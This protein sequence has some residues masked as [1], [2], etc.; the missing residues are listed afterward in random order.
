MLWTRAAVVIVPSWPAPEVRPSE[1]MVAALR[2]AESGGATVMGLC[3]GACALGYAGLLDG[4]RALTHW[5]QRLLT[6]FAARFP[7]VRERNAGLYI[8][9]GSVITSAG[10]AAGLD[11]CLHYVRRVRRP[12]RS[13]EA[14]SLLPTAVAP[15]T[16]SLRQVISDRP[17]RRSLTFRR[18]L[19]ANL[20]SISLST[21]WRVGSA[22]AAAPSTAPSPRKQAAP[23]AG[24]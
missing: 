9:E 8:D 21:C 2:R 23:P 22:R 1:G 4:R 19:F 12:R 11:A 3:L 18:E 7:E 20:M 5:R 10:S 13:P 16:S 6:D 17:E 14:W 24:G 15:T